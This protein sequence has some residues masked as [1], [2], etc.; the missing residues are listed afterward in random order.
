MG[1]IKSLYVSN[2]YKILVAT[3]NDKFELPDGSYSISDIQDYFEY[4]WKKH[5]ERINNSLANAQYFKTFNTLAA[6]VF[7]ARLAQAN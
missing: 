2:K 7:N 3:W 4:I 6:S 5:N 1:N